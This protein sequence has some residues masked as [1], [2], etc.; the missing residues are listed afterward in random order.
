MEKQVMKYAVTGII[1]FLLLA[2]ISALVISINS[3]LTGEVGTENMGVMV[4]AL[5]VALIFA[6]LAGFFFVKLF[7]R[8]K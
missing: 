4:T 7:E 3:L 5:V 8:V 1:I 6:I 2:L